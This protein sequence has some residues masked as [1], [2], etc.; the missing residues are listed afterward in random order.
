MF[1]RT[2]VIRIDKSLKVIMYSII[3]IGFAVYLP[4]SLFN[5]FN[6]IRLLIVVLF[7]IFNVFFARFIF[8]SGLKRYTSSNMA[9][10][11][12]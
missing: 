7:T 12:V 8:Y 1:D 4:I 9:V 11:S 5:D 3:P 6:I 10:V 2:I